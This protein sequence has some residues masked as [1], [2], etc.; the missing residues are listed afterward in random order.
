[1][2]EDRWHGTLKTAE[3]LAKIETE[4]GLRIEQ[5]TIRS[6]VNRAENPLVPAYTGKNGQAHRFVWVDFL[7]WYDQYGDVP[8]T[9]GREPTDPD[10]LDWHGARTV[11]A[12]AQA[13]RD[14][15]LTA[16]LEG[17]YGDIKTM[18]QTSENAARQAV[19]ALLA[20]PSRIAPRLAVLTD[21]LAIDRLLDAEIRQVCADLE[22]T[23]LRAIDLDDEPQPAEAA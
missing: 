2:S 4:L 1:M 5:V 9:H 6:W 20:I 16:R 14:I 15:L 12:R 21:E 11:S 18:E 7:S 10:D 17:K 3:L 13:K 22:A 23:A 8:N 19:L